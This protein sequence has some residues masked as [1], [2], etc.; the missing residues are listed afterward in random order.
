MNHAACRNPVFCLTPPYLLRRI[1]RNG[2]P[3]QRETATRTLASDGTFR[4]LRQA[5]PPSRAPD[6]GVRGVLEPEGRKRRTIF[7]VGNT[8]NLPGRVARTEGEGPSGDAA[9]DEAYDGLGATYDFFWEVYERDSIDD[10]GLPLNGHV[11]FG[12]DYANAFWDGER[13]VFGDGDGEL[14]NRFTISLDVMGH[15]LSHGVTQ[16]ES[17]LNYMGQPGALNEHLSDVYGSL[18]KQYL[19][20]QTAEEADWLIGAGLLTE[21]VDGVALRSM[22]EPGTAFDDEVLGEDPQPAHMD[23]FV[24]T[25]EDNGG[26][27]I[28]SGIPN[29]AFYLAAAALGGNAWEVA[30]RI[31]NAT[32]I[33]PRLKPDTGFRRF[34]RLT[35]R[36]AAS[37]YGSG[38]REEDAVRGAWEGVGITP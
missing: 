20:G 19:L 1:A 36:N 31:W 25:F 16:Y 27:H 28:N 2:S 22:R 34:A 37:L 6:A 14:F 18:V 24:R 38:G 10:D 26:V 12:V 17:G 23:D 3:A 13:M 21:N 15:E 33:D 29:R 9:V 30:G 11:H 8:Q 7:D 35:A 4:S 5:T 32:A